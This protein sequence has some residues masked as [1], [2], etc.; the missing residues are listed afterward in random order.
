MPRLEL[1]EQLTHN[2]LNLASQAP[3]FTL[4]STVREKRRKGQQKKR[5]GDSMKQ[6]LHVSLEFAKSLSATRSEG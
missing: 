1:V 6:L 2:G 3:P 5:W 4:Q